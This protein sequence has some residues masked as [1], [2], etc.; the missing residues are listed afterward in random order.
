M[1]ETNE[2][3]R[4]FCFGL[5]YSALALAEALQQR[6]WRVAGTCRGE[7]KRAA[8]TE[9]GIEAVP[10]DRERGLEDAAAVLSGATHLLFSIPPDG[11]GESG[12]PVVDLLGRRIAGIEGLR[13]AGYLSTTGVY[14]DRDGGWVDETSALLPT[15]E[16]G[17]RRVAAEKAWLGLWRD[18]GVPV[19]LF[20]LAGIYG[21]GR[22]ALETVR[23][24]R[25]QRIDKPGQVFSRIHRDDIV[26]ILLASMDRPDPGAAYNCCDDNPAPPAEVIE[27]ACT[28]LG[29]EP[30][31]LV[32]FD[33]AEL[34]PMARSFYR[35]N[36]R[37]SNERMKREL[38]VVLRWPDYRAA[39][40]ALAAE[41]AS[42]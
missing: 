34:S 38:G 12:D 35:D 9:R 10:F 3:G 30:P 15:G 18:R 29:V 31:P 16:R 7:E 14:G 36:K 26:A 40:A 23:A 17:R 13:W 41:T 32:P 37:V 24:G 25:A 5:G 42:T 39:L 19:H 2:P 22:N 1:S 6:G 27:Y 11:A 4:L 28:L 20:R 8:L 33:K 21:P